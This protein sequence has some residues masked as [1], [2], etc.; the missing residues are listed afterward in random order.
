MSSYL[1]LYLLPKKWENAEESP[2]PLLFKSWSRNTDMY[3][4]FRD[5]C[6]PTYIGNGDKSQYSKLNIKDLQYGIN[7]EEE[8]L[9]KAEQ[10]LNDRLATIKELG[11]SVPKEVVDEYLEDL[12]STRE[13]IADTRET[14]NE[15]KVLCDLLSYEFSDFGEILINVD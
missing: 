10:R 3:D 2:R 13:Y 5:Y 14:L 8:L 7:K 4:L 1:N 15:A 12:P 6:N 9:A 11:K